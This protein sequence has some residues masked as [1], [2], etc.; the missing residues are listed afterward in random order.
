MD[1]ILKVEVQMHFVYG[2][3]F[4]AHPLTQNKMNQNANNLYP[5]LIS[6]VPSTT[7]VLSLAT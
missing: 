4:V 1:C 3:E 5:V 6:K 2:R 7:C